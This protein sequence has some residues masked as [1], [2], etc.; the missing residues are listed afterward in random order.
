MVNTDLNPA[1]NRPMELILSGFVDEPTAV[2][3]LTSL[4]VNLRFPL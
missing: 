1:P 3:D 2:I 4:K